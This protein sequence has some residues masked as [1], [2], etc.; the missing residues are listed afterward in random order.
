[1]RLLDCFVE[2]GQICIVLEYLPEPIGEANL[3]DLVAGM[4]ELH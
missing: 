3:K 1:V 2:A 4:H